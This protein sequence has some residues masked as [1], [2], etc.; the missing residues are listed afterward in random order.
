LETKNSSKE[1]LKTENVVRL[2]A[3]FLRYL[4]CTRLTTGGFTFFRI[5]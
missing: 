2:V 3:S 4:A 5:L 1:I